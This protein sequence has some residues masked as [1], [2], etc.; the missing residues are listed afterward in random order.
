LLMPVHDVLCAVAWFELLKRS[1]SVDVPTFLYASVIFV[2]LCNLG[3]RV[4]FKGAL[5]VSAIIST[6]IIGNVALLH[7]GDPKALLV[8]VLVYLPVLFFSLFIAWT[9]IVSVH[10]AFLADQEARWQQAQLYDLNQRLQAL[11][12]TDALTRVGNRRA[13]DQHL[14]ERWMLMEQVGQPFGLLLVD[15]DYFKPFNDH[16][17]HQAGDRCLADVARVMAECVGQGQLFRYGGEEFAILVPLGAKAALSAQAER[18][19]REVQ[20]LEI[21]HHHRPDGLGLLTV[22][23]GAALCD[24]PGAQQPHDLFGCCDRLL[25]QAKQQGRNR[26]CTA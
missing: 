1:H 8:F 18:L 21:V 24:N 11:A 16:Y 6:V 12:I 10:R 19:V 26:V 25:Y 9:N 22:S 2:L 3:V 7:H 17:G 23:I 5:W 4:S 13:F 20:Q 14:S 15:I